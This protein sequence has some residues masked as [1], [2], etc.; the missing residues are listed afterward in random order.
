MEKVVFITYFTYL[1]KFFLF[2]NQLLTACNHLVK[3][4]QPVLKPLDGFHVLIIQLGNCVTAICQERLN[5]PWVKLKEN[6]AVKIFFPLQFI[7]THLKHISKNMSNV[8]S[9]THPI[10]G[11]KAFP[12]NR[13][14]I[15]GSVLHIDPV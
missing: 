14:H 13:F 3:S 7:T 12:H 1:S 8:T 2:I 9:V 6:V 11:V 4:I 10:D 5:D 15:I